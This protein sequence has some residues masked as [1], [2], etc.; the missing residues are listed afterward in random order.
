MLEQLDKMLERAGGL[1]LAG[2]LQR[3]IC[4]ILARQEQLQAPHINNRCMGDRRWR[5]HF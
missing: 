5:Y 2:W 4:R 3:W 1:A